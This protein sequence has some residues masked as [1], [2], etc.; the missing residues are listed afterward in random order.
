MTKKLCTKKTAQV[1]YANNFEI[2]VVAL[3]LSY[4]ESK[5][6][7][8]A[9]LCEACNGKSADGE[10]RSTQLVSDCRWEDESS[11]SESSNKCNFLKGSLISDSFKWV[12]LKTLKRKQGL[13]LKVNRWQSEC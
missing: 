9:V 2:I 11:S 3:I 12:L 6:Q 8:S 1:F 7:L 4:L 13:I 10:G 5:V